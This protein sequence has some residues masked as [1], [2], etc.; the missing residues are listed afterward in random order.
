MAE[1]A[2]REAARGPAVGQLAQPGPVP[3]GGVAFSALPED[4]VGGCAGLT[5]QGRVVGRHGVV[6][7]VDGGV[8]GRRGRGGPTQAG[9][10]KATG[11]LRADG[12]AQRTGPAA[13]QPTWKSTCPS[14]PG[15][16][17]LPL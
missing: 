15:R 7:V 2:Y 11:R 1:R 16:K 14:A 17:G 10:C 4:S 3:P 9:S 12:D 5:G 6:V 8:G 13:W